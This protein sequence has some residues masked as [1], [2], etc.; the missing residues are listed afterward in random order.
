V[1]L[2]VVDDGFD[3]KVLILDDRWV[4]RIPRRQQVLSALEQEIALLPKLEAALPVAVP[5][6]EL[7]SRNPHLVVYPLIQGTPLID[8]DP[9]GVRGFLDSLHHLQT[10]VLPPTDWI[11]S[12][13]EQCERFEDLVLPLLDRGERA[14]AQAFF[15]EVETLTGFDPCVTHSDLGAEHLLVREGKLVGVIDWGDARLG[16]PAL[17]YSWLL[18]GPFPDWDVDPELRRRALFYHRLAPFFSVH[19][20]V[21]TKR[22]DYVEQALVRLRSRL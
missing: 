15:T 11:A 3:F 2:V 18:H 6:L 13:T 7:I 5:H 20:G 8:E 14:R 9:E 21:F 4:V 1:S 16:D 17:D 10:D 12:Y 19:Y 22:P